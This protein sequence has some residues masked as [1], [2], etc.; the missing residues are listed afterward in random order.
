MARCILDLNT[1]ISRIFQS[2][3]DLVFGFIRENDTTN[4]INTPESIIKMCLLYAYKVAFKSSILSPDECTEL[5]Q[6]IGK[7]RNKY[8][9]EWKLLYRGSRD[10]Y[11]MKGCHQR[12]YSRSNVVL[13]VESTQGNVFG[14]F[15]QVGWDMNA[16]TD[17]YRS[18]PNAFLFLIRSKSH[19]HKHEIF[20]IKDDC[21]DEALFHF[22][23]LAEWGGL[24]AFGR[25]GHD[26][27]ISQDCNLKRNSASCF[28]S[29]DCLNSHV[30]NGKRKIRVK[31][32]ELFE[33]L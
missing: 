31:D 6:M 30:L 16:K 3:C 23:P 12:C 11:K 32:M 13:I 10:G 18:D 9:S 19:D 20:K 24:F 22:K 5:H 2:Y 1:E 14:G 17:E 21:H 8:A 29:F 26:L 28:C 25:Y 15:T 33:L 7:H 27:G 4:D